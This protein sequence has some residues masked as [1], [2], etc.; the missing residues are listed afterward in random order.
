MRFG[1][2]FPQ[3]EIGNDPAAIRDLVQSAEGLGYGFVTLIDHVLQTRTAKGPAMA[4]LY[5]RDKPFHEVFTLAAF[6]AGVTSSIVLTPAVLV[7]PQRQTA[8]VAKQAAEVDVL[9]G[10]RFRLGIGI[11]WSEAEYEAV[12]QSFK[13]RARRVEEQV[14]VL[15]ALWC[16]ETITFKGREHDIDDCGLNPLPM[17]RP[18]PIWFGG[19]ADAALS[20]LGRL[21]DGWY[22]FPRMPADAPDTLRQFSLV[23]A[24]AKAAGRD[25][26]RLGINATVYAGEGGSQAW[27]AEARKWLAA[28]ATE[29]TFRTQGLGK[30]DNHLD[31]LQ[32][33][34]AT[35]KAA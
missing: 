14:A 32:R 12:G 5:T 6:L 16:N 7:L 33:F 29:I 30:I 34:A 1:L 3:N 20:R 21:G 17:Q 15:R 11:G 4:A 2:S 24:A 27:L 18:I 25:P 22:A 28:G 19:A 10:G 35:V 9:S 26:A 23:R 31:A 13:T 8:V